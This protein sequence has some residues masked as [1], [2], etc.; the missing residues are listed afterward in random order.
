MTSQVKSVSDI[1]EEIKKSEFEQI[2]YHTPSDDFFEIIPGKIPILISA[3]HGANHKRNGQPKEENEYTSSIA[4]ML[5]HL[6]GAHVIY[7]RTAAN[8]DPI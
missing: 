4:I 1:L 6:T 8:E 7:A 3:P 2:N 5:G